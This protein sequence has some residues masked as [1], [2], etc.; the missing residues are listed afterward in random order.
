M[1]TELSTLVLRELGPHDEAPFLKWFSS[2]PEDDATWAT[3][4]WK[5]GMSHPEHLQILE[6]QKDKLKIPSN[7][8]PS[9]MLYAFVGEE[10]VGR[11]SVRH[12]LNDFLLSRGGHLGYSVSLLH[13]RMG[14][15]SEMFRQGLDF[16]R[17]LGLESILITCAD[18]N[19]PSWKIIEKFGGKLENKVFIEE[20]DE[21][22]R[23]YWIKLKN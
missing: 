17:K 11:L 14:I 22:I 1:T 5:E 8:V 12:E 3:F 9:T 18:E 13:R 7:R 16:C 6:D 2:W 20:D 10:I 19:T 4:V 15:A 23:R 21:L